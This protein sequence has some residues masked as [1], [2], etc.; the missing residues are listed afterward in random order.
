MKIK[1]LGLAA[2]LA[3]LVS[4]E[5]GHAQDLLGGAVGGNIATQ[6][7]SQL[8]QPATGQAGVQSNTAVG[9]AT[10]VGGLQGAVNNA[11]QNGVNAAANAS[12]QG[13]GIRGT[14][15]QG[16]NGAIEGAANG[17]VQGN[18]QGNAQSNAQGNLQGNAQGNLQ[19]TGNALPGSAPNAPSQNGARVGVANLLQGVTIA[20]DG[21]IRLN[22]QQAQEL[23]RIGLQ[24]NDRII[25][26]NG[27]VVTDSQ[28]IQS[29][30]ANNNGF[31]V[32]RNGQLIKLQ[33]Q[34]NGPPQPS[35]S[36]N[37]N[38]Q[39]MSLQQKLALIEQLVREVRSEISSTR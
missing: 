23:S 35:S 37:M 8:G 4:T 30:F 1:I 27:I 7:G 32:L 6:V 14:L 38:L 11:I 13:Q 16:V 17:N 5:T 33:V 3:S 20:S 25:D 31:R 28:Q 39:N 21:S 24:S 29:A 36:N 19:G 34:P 9:G 12:A 2:A 26:A 15:Q 10:Q 18:V 22:G